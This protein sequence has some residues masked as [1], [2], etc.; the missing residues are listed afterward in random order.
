MKKRT[1]KIP[2]NFINDELCHKVSITYEHE[3][4][5]A[6]ALLDILLSKYMNID[7]RKKYNSIEVTEEE[8]QTWYVYFLEYYIDD[9]SIFVGSEEEKQAK[10]LLRRMRNFFGAYTY[11]ERH[12]AGAKFKLLTSIVQAVH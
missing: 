10:Y 4:E 11:D 6:Y 12:R 3:T 1:F 5:R 2:T 7:N 8:Y 9:Q